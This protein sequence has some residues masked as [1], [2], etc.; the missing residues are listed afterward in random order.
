MP[1]D[2]I[3]SVTLNPLE[4]R[5]LTFAT[6]IVLAILLRI[7]LP[8]RSHVSARVIREVL[9]IL[10]A[11]LLYFLVRGLVDGN[12]E[13]AARH[14][15]QIISLEKWLGIWVELDMQS[16]ILGSA[17][18]T[19]VVNWVYI[20]AHWPVIAIV[21]FW[22]VLWHFDHY[23][24]YRNALLISG[25]AGMIIFATYPV[26]PPRLMPEYNF[27]DTVTLQSNSYRVLQPPSLTN[28]YAAMPNL[29][30]GWN[31]LMGIALVRES[32]KLPVRILGFLIPI[33][34]F[35]SIILSGNHYIL[36]AGV[37]GALVLA[38]LGCSTYLANS[39]FNFEAICN[40]FPTVRESNRKPVPHHNQ[41]P[42]RN[43]RVAVRKIASTQPLAPARNVLAPLRQRP[44]IVAHRFGNTL[45]GLEQARQAGADIIEADVWPYRGQLEVRHTKTLGPLP[46][47][48]DRWSI[49]PGWKPRLQFAELLAALGPDTLLMIDIKGRDPTTPG[50]IIET[51]HAIRP[52]KPVIVCSQNWDQ[53]ERFRSYPEA[54]RVYSIGNRRQLRRAWRRLDNKAWDAVSIQA[55]LLDARVVQGLKER[56]RLVMT[57]AVDTPEHLDQVIGW[58]V[59]GITSNNLS[60]IAGFIEHRQTEPTRCV[61]LSLSLGSLKQSK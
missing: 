31:L 52:G 33:S 18:R 37:G 53:V 29:H 8:W 13:T 44:F 9:I 15:E 35:L 39:A 11:V 36:D 12:Y 5:S 48:W 4:W 17:W 20:W 46:V 30:F 21:V 45:K 61:S 1:M 40:R 16:I 50:R 55:R 23:P 27:V 2:L 22:L 19:D 51:L 60:L 54:L 42:E 25:V 28:P 57:W 47:L 6:L 59:D 49:E 26:A 24:K 7:A 56:V 43:G 41:R 58:G 3:L 10:P 32:T 38:S 14:A 34:M